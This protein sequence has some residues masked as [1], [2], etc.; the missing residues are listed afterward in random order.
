MKVVKT[1]STLGAFS[2]A[3]GMGV[4]LARTDST[5]EL[6]RKLIQPNAKGIVIETCAGEAKNLTNY[7][8]ARVK[9]LILVDRKVN[10][11]LARIVHPQ[12]RVAE[13]DILD[14]FADDSFDTVVDSVL[15]LLLL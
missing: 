11:A 3:L 12:T 9:E 10:E 6:R 1:L 15:L 7:D 14:E 13:C 4:E 5:P 8:F 2:I